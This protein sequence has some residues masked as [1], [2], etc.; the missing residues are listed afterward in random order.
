MR[1]KFPNNWFHRATSSF[2]SVAGSVPRICLDVET[3]SSQS[4]AYRVRVDDP[5]CPAKQ[6]YNISK[7]RCVAGRRKPAQLRSIYRRLGCADTLR[8]QATKTRNL[9][10]GRC[11]QWKDGST[12]LQNK[13]GEYALTFVWR[14]DNRILSRVRP[15]DERWPCISSE[16]NDAG[17]ISASPPLVSSDFRPAEIFIERRGVANF[18]N[19]VAAVSAGRF[20]PTMERHG[21]SIGR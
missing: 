14:E 2:P 17:F 9:I 3:S 1:R 16:F 12:Q 6:S 4:V 13:R 21:S 10:S 5:I 7:G 20:L 11:F 15:V 19:R 18:A 8:S